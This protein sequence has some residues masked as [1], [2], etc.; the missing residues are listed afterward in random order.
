L[1]GA[2]VHQ[3]GDNET[4]ETQDFGEN[5]NENH[6]DK[7]TWLLSSSTDTGLVSLAFILKV[8]DRTYVTNNADGEASSK[9]CQTDSQPST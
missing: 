9:T 4:V 5:E 7:E 2:R 8:V 6:S 1:S 3:K